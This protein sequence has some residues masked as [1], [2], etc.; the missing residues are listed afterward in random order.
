MVGLVDVIGF[1]I[2]RDLSSLLIVAL[3]VLSL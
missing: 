1:W 2:K 3:L